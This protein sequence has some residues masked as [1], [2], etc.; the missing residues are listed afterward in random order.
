M[1]A[2]VYIGLSKYRYKMPSPRPT[3]PVVLRHLDTLWKGLL[4][5]WQHLRVSLGPRSHSLPISD[6]A[7]FQTGPATLQYPNERLPVP[8]RGRYRLHN[9]I[10]D[11]IVCD[12][13]TKVCPVDCIEIDSIKSPVPIGKTSNGMTKRL[14]AARFDIDLAKCCFCGLCTTVC[15]TQCLTMTPEYD[16]SVFDWAEH[17][18]PFATLTPEEARVHQQALGVKS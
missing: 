5:A 4:L 15:P 10:D 6:A 8:E 16:Y 7:Y 17:K 2:A 12:K 18:V 9:A 11:C 13:C 1:V 14:Y 3:C